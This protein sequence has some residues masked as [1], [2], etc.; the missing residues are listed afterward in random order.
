MHI[1]A[2]VH[3]L[4]S[5]F[6]GILLQLPN[7]VAVLLQQEIKNQMITLAPDLNTVDFCGFLNLNPDL[8]S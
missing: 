4:Y 3:V 7:S 2:F 6:G 5:Y 8:A 1:S